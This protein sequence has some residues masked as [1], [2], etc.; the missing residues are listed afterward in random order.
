M[1]ALV[2]FRTVPDLFKNL[3][4]HYDGSERAAL[5]YKDKQSKQWID[6]T[7]SELYDRVLNVAAYLHSRGVRKGDRVA[8]LSENRPE[9]AIVD[10]ATQWLAGV[11]V[12]LYT[13]LPASQVEYIVRDS[14]SILLFVSTSIQLRSQNAPHHA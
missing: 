12:S 1:P 11:N 3:V 14:G 10:L 4:N 9:W 5:S 2:P 13:S 6:I 7:W 8:I